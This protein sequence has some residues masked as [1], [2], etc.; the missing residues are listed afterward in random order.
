MDSSS[1]SWLPVCNHWISYSTKERLGSGSQSVRWH[2]RP[3]SQSCLIP[4]LSWRLFIALVPSCWHFSI[5]SWSG[6]LARIPRWVSVAHCLCIPHSHSQREDL[7]A[8]WKGILGPSIWCEAFPLPIWMEVL[9]CYR[10]QT[11][12]AT[13][14][15]ADKAIP[16]LAA[17]HNC[18]DW[19]FCSLLITMTS[20]FTVLKTVPMLM[21]CLAF[22]WRFLLYREKLS[23]QAACFNLGQFQSLPVTSSEVATATRQ[24][25]IL[26]EVLLYAQQGWP[27]HVPES[28]QPFSSCRHELTWWSPSIVGKSSM[29]YNTLEALYSG[30]SGVTPRS[31]WHCTQVVGMKLLLMAR[32]W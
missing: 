20:V 5:W 16:F 19:P 25:P 30:P 10:P 27:A 26:S 12:I 8:N 7:P 17:Q 24:G 13:N 28:M 14:L 32:I 29:I 11:T 1:Q 4:S 22:L 23:N 2:L 9:P 15:V 3:S 21:G 31:W 18:R 6:D